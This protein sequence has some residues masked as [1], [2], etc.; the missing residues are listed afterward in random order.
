M[1]RIAEAAARELTTT[2]TSPHTEVFVAPA[3]ELKAARDAVGLGRA[4][5][6]ANLAGRLKF[7]PDG[8]PPPGCRV[9]V[10]DDIVTT[11]ATAAACVAALK[12]SGVAVAAVL[13]LLAA[14]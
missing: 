8:R 9:V 12:S 10:L 6:I 4:E 14:G 7:V 11:G 5:R 3:L 2:E 1:L 13:T